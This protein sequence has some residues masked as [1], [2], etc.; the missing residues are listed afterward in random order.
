MKEI[1]IYV[2]TIVK[3]IMFLSA[4]KSERSIDNDTIMG[5]LLQTEIM[6]L[7]LLYIITANLS[8]RKTFQKKTL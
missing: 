4:E 1:Y 5:N 2:R 6:N 8:F 7:Q 3:N